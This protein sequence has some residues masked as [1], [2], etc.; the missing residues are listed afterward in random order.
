MF[1]QAAATFRGKKFL[2]AAVLVAL[3]PILAALVDNPDPVP[4]VRLVLHLQFAFLI[5]TL[6]ISLGSG[7]LYEEAEEG[8]LTFLFTSPVPKSSVV[9]GKW[10]AALACGWAL[11]L[12]SLGATFL[13]T[14]ADL[15]ALGGFVKA[16]FTAALFGIPAYLGLFTFLG[17]LFR[18]GYIVG[19]IYCFGF[20]LILWVVPGAAKRL[21]IGYFLRSLIDPYVKD[22][23]PFEGYFDTFP[24]DP[25]MVCFA[26][27]TG[28]AVVF[29]AGTLLIVPGKEFRTRNVQG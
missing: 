5:P 23:T 2:G 7:L 26:V 28:L 4:L 29:V 20:E 19:L 25:E 8:T 27:L 11:S 17:T 16:S 13:L 9:L 6:A 24:A 12:A 1:R 21:S 10:C 3:S 14:K 22:K 18:R 15:G